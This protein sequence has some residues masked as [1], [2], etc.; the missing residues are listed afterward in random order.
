MNAKLLAISNEEEMSGLLS[1]AGHLIFSDQTFLEQPLLD[2]PLSML[3]HTLRID[4][5]LRRL[6]L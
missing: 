6:V 1:C 5:P 4:V 2:L 3:L